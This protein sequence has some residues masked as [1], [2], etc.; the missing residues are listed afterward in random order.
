[1]VIQGPKIGRYPDKENENFEIPDRA[2]R[3]RGN[4][5]IPSKFIFGISVGNWIWCRREDCQHK[6]CSGHLC[7]TDLTFLIHFYRTQVQS[8]SCLYHSI[9]MSV[10][11]VFAKKT[12][13][14]ETVQ[15][16]FVDLNRKGGIPPSAKQFCV[17]R[18]L[19][20]KQVTPPLPFVDHP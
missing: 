8:L 12:R 6:P 20:D 11:D 18:N 17:E 19:A 14:K 7:S 4:R 9:N 16:Y 1:M 3:I 10:S 13:L 2:N 15:Y 5:K